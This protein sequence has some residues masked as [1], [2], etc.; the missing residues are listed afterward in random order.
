MLGKLTEQQADSPLL[1]YLQYIT[2]CIQFNWFNRVEVA[3]NK[4]RNQSFK[5]A[6]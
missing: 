3:T 2:I 4:I 5:H 1:C 6:W